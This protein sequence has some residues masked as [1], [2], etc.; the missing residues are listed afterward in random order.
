MIYNRLLPVVY[1]NNILSRINIPIPYLQL[2]IQHWEAVFMHIKKLIRRA[3]AFT[4]ILL[5]YFLGLAV[6]TINPPTAQAA[7]DIQV[8]V[9]GKAVVIDVSATLVQGRTLVPLR[10]SSRH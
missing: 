5:I 9:N 4:A 6:G 10:I 8:E 3:R 1:G 2:A 7:R